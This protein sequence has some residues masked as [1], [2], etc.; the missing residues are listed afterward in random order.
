MGINW[1]QDVICH[2][3]GRC[4][5]GWCGHD[6]D[7]VR[8]HD[9]EWG[10]PEFDGRKLY[11]KLTLDTFQAGLSWLVIL[12]KRAH[13]RRAFAGFDLEK[14]ARFDEA[15][16]HKLMQ[17]AGIVRNRAKIEAAIVNARVI[18]E[19][20]GP[21]WFSRWLWNFVDGQPLNPRFGSRAQVPDSTPLS[22]RIAREMKRR[23]FRFC[24]PVIVYAFMQ[25]VGM[26]NDH[27][28]SCHR[29]DAVAQMAP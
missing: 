24:G 12:K 13:F 2:A 15:D 22:E 3:D 16:V 17:D 9:E 1:E 21:E 28:L 29:H 8:Y 23:G 11:E 5:C 18:L 4:R 10:V 6:A 27:L 19:H 26:S 7:Y 14:V 25:A 20:G